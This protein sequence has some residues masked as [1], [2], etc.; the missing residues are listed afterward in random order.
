MAYT[1]KP[2]ILPK[3]APTTAV[4][5]FTSTGVTIIEKMT[6]TNVSGSDATLTVHLVPSGGSIVA[7]NTIIDARQIASG[8]CYTCP[9]IPGHVLAAGGFIAVSSDTGSAIVIAASGLEIT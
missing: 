9:E 8:E 5:E 6:A 1:A 2:L 4:G 3:Y 7:A